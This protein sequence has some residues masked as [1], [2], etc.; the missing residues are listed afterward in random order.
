MTGK[1]SVIH[2][3]RD[4]NYKFAIKPTDSLNAFGETDDG[5]SVTNIEL[6]KN[7]VIPF[8][9][10]YSHHFENPYAAYLIPFDI[11]VGEA[12]WIKVLIEDIVGGSWNQGDT[13]RLLSSEAI[14]NGKDLIVNFK[15]IGGYLINIG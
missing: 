8:T 6:P 2:D 1:I 10:Y 14:W 4:D 11:K 3:F 7:T 12:V 9:F 15:T 13:F 5:S